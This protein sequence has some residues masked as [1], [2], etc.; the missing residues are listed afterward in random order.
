MSIDTRL[1][2]PNNSQE[3]PAAKENAADVA[4]PNSPRPSV[5]SLTQA[6]LARLG[7]RNALMATVALSLLTNVLLAMTLLT[8]RPSSRTII[9]PP[10]VLDEKEAWRFTEAGP[11]ANYLSRWSVSLLH[12]L[13]TVTPATI[14]H[15]REIVLSHT[16]P[17]FFATLET[18]LVTEADHLKKDRLSTVFTPLRLNVNEKA[19]TVSADGEFLLL[20][21]DTVTKREMKRFTLTYRYLGGLLLLSGADAR[22][23]TEAEKRSLILQNASPGK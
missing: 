3:T 22:A 6:G 20:M 18:S 21:G 4:F 9:V 10:T 8:H 15:Q 19:L 16:A 12:A 11:S 7:V 13:T 17:E 23:L 14:D 5:I 1:A 2:T